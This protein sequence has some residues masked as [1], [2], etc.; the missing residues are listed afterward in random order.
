MDEFVIGLEKFAQAGAKIN[1][2]YALEEWLKMQ[3]KKNVENYIMKD[4]IQEM[5]DANGIPPE[6]QPQFKQ[7]IA[8]QA[9]GVINAQQQ[10]VQPPMYPNENPQQVG[11][12]QDVGAYPQG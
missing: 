9:Q 3:E 8:Q 12:V 10:Q 7:M 4:P 5:M 11:G 2:D 1:I 6:M